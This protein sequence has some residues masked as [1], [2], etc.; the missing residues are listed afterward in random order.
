VPGD[1]IDA[2]AIGTFPVNAGPPLA[3]GPE[4]VI[5]VSLTR[6]S[7]SSSIAT[8]AGGDGIIQVFP[9]PHQLVMNAKVLG[10][11]PADELDAITGMDP[12]TPPGFLPVENPG[13]NFIFPDQAKTPGSPA[14]WNVTE[15]YNGQDISD[16]QSALEVLF[17]GNPLVRE[18]YTSPYLS[19]TDGF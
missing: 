13:T 2:L 5:W 17:L 15:V 18:E 11:D 4:V 6:G 12:G 16:I 10:L 3:L 9:G 7:P 1:D 8:A 14:F 19:L